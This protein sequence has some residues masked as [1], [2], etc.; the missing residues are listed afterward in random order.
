MGQCILKIHK[1]KSGKRRVCPY[2]YYGLYEDDEDKFFAK[3]Q[4]AE[5]VL[6]RFDEDFNLFRGDNPGLS[7]II[8]YPWDEITSESIMLE[9][10]RQYYY[11]ILSN[12]LNID[13]EDPAK[14]F[15]QIVYPPDQ[16]HVEWSW[17]IGYGWLKF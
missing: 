17:S 3:P 4:E 16:L 11:A 5:D 10:V 1:L 15:F 14:E 9:I 2:G 13:I 7:V 8:P 6:E 12:D